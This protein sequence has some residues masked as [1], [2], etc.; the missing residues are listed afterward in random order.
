MRKSAKGKD[1][2][3]ETRDVKHGASKDS[4]RDFLSGVLASSAAL[5]GLGLLSEALGS[6]QAEAAGQRR[7]LVLELRGSPVKL[8]SLEN[9]ISLEVSSKELAQHLVNEGIVDPKHRQGLATVRYDLVI[10]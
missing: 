6:S 8:K 5:A 2:V 4:R 3:E 1:G 7:P 10:S 9:G